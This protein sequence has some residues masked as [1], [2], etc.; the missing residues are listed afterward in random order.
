MLSRI[1]F[2]LPFV[3]IEKFFHW[4]VVSCNRRV[5][6]CDNFLGLLKE[7]L[8]YYTCLSRP[9]PP[10][11]SLSFLSFPT[12]FDGKSLYNRNLIIVRANII[13]AFFYTEISFKWVSLKLSASSEDIKKEKK[14]SFDTILFNEWKQAYKLSHA[15]SFGLSEWMNIELFG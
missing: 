4:I 11:L 1:A 5:W 10:S 7:M 13:T 9:L 3:E 2:S 15:N 6:R 12:I 8:A 14:T